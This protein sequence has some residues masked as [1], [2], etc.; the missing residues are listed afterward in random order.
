MMAQV[1]QRIWRDTRFHKTWTESLKLCTNL[2]KVKAQLII[3]RITKLTRE[4]TRF[5]EGKKL[6]GLD[7][8]KC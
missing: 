5:H 2:G 6:C 1:F 7:N 4:G 3:L 8:T